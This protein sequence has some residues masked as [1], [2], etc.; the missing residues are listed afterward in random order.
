MSSSALSSLDEKGR[1]LIP[2]SLREQVGLASGEKVLI[3]VNSTSK[4][5]SIEPAHEK[6]LLS[7]RIE[8]ADKPGALAKAALALYDLGIDLVSTHS[9]SSK[10]G[11]AAQWQVECNP[12]GVSASDIKAALAKAGA[13]LASSQWV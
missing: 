9:R 6:R 1:V 8:L 4:A 12:K 5:L 3:S 13:K 11:E 2:L 10:R 7:L